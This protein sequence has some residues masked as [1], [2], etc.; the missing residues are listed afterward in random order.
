MVVAEVVPV[1]VSGTM[2]E[3][4]AEMVREMVTRTWTYALP[5]DSGAAS[6]IEQ[7]PVS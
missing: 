4:V 6:P 3:T 1:M 5:L 2:A 7:L